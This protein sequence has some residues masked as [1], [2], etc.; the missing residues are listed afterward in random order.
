MRKVKALCVT[1]SARLFALCEDGTL[2]TSPPF[3]VGQPKWEPI[4]GPPEGRMFAEEETLEKKADRLRKSG[5][6]GM[7]IGRGLKDED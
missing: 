6:R 1:N 2:W 4:E 5:G 7:I 3:E